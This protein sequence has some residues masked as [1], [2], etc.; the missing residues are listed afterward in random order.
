MFNGCKLDAPV[1]PDPG[2]TTGPGG[3]D[4]PVVV[5]DTDD[6]TNPPADATYTVPIGAANTIVF[7]VDGGETVILDQ[8]KAEV[9]Q[10]GSVAVTGYTSILGDKADPEIIFQLNFS[11]IVQGEYANDLLGL[12][13]Q[14]LKLSDDGSGKVKAT[15]YKKIGD[16]YH[17]RGFF[18]V[19]ATNDTDGS[20]HTVIGSFNIE[21]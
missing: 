18:K 7:Q 8:S 13:Y 11:S 19:Q 16:S 6:G 2:G 4:P 9:S 10:P 5:P 3:T 21:Q 14:D 17:I 15:T 12:Q 1:Y 20:K